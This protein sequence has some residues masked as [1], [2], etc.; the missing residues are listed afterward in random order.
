[1]KMLIQVLPI[2][3]HNKKPIIDEE[4]R[5]DILFAVSSQYITSHPV[6]RQSRR[7]L[8]FFQLSVTLRRNQSFFLQTATFQNNSFTQKVSKLV[9]YESYSDPPNTK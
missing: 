6:K 2:L 9:F 5:L 1:M 4:L 8:I 3:K 7:L